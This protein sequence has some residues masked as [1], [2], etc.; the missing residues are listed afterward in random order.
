MATLYKLT[1]PD[2]TTYGDFQWTLGKTE[3]ALGDGPLCSSSWLHAY[4]DPLLAVFLNPI[5][6]NFANPRLF[7]CEGEVQANDH[8][9]KVGCT[10]L[11]LVKEIA[12]PEVSLEQR[13]AFGILCTKEVYKEENWNK[14]AD[15]W[16]AG[17]NRGESAAAYAVRAAFAA[18]AAAYAVRA[19]YATYAA[20]VAAIVTYATYATFTAYTAET[21]AA[22]AAR[23]ARGATH[24]AAHVTTSL[25]T[26]AK[27]AMTMPL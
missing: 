18:Y 25:A 21:A 27:Q 13:I 4:T 10:V 3:T 7:E 24:A 15:D 12:L 2:M 11:T 26:L 22:A 5:H 1:S 14:W 23:A 6:A 20:A 8:G 16:L 17:K 9:L 19:A